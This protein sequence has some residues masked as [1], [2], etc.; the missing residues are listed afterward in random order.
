M[1]EKYFH[2][3][4]GLLLS[5]AFTST[6]IMHGGW[7]KGFKAKEGSEQKLPIVYSS[8]YTVGTGWA[9][10]DAALN[11]LHPFDLKKYTKIHAAL[12]SRLN[13]TPEQF[14]TPQKAVSDETLQKV[15]TPEYLASLNDSTAV[16]RVAEVPPLS[17]VPNS[18]LQRIVLNP[19]R[20][21]TAGT[22]QAAEL[23]QKEGWAINIGGGFH[24]AKPKSG[25][26]FCYYN[27]L[28][29]AVKTVQEKNPHAKIMIVDLDAHQ[30]NGTSK[31]TEKNSNVF[32][33]DA[34]NNSIYYPADKN[35]TKVDIR[36]PLASYTE[37]DEYLDNLND[38]LNKAKKSFKPDLIIYNAGTDIFEGD[39]VGQLSVSK[40]GIIKRDARVFEFAKEQEA[41][42]M[43]VL[44]GG[45]TQESAGIV[46]DSIVNLV[47]TYDLTNKNHK[48]RSSNQQPPRAKSLFMTSMQ[49]SVQVPTV[50]NETPWYATFLNRMSQVNENP[51]E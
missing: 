29:L 30:G 2:S 35:K 28:A 42:I 16:A 3:I 24:H 51:F 34:Y 6:T 25:E 11:R 23:A 12:M 15:H 19:M 13:L 49:E 48:L 44:S 10:I 40:E 21:A 37:D 22:V 41:P 17:S 39:R 18:I 45:Y 47:K 27:D 20:Y 33:V 36:V 4:C 9:V 14:H 32:I 46:S 26:G 5:V 38:A 31:C 8:N 50:K 43:M 7:I 1:N